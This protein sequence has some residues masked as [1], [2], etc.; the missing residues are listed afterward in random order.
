MTDEMLILA[1]SAQDMSERLQGLE[2]YKISTNKNDS[3]VTAVYSVDAYPQ[4]NFMMTS[5]DFPEAVVLK[6]LPSRNFEKAD[7]YK[8]IRNKEDLKKSMEDFGLDIAMLEI[9]NKII[10]ED[11]TE[12]TEKNIIAEVQT[13]TADST[14]IM[15]GQVDLM[16]YLVDPSNLNEFLK[17]EVSE[18]AVSDIVKNQEGELQLK[19]LKANYDG[20]LFSQHSS[21]RDAIDNPEVRKELEQSLATTASRVR[22]KGLAEIQRLNSALQNQQVSFEDAKKA[23]QFKET[24]YERKLEEETRPLINKII[25]D[26]RATHPDDTAQK[27]AEAKKHYEETLLN[28]AKHYVEQAEEDLRVRLMKE[29]KGTID[30][31]GNRDVDAIVSYLDVKNHLVDNFKQMVLEAKEGI[32]HQLPPVQQPVATPN[33]SNENDNSSEKIAELSGNIESLAKTVETFA[34]GQSEVS[35][36]SLE[37]INKY[38]KLYEE[39]QKALEEKEAA[40]QKALAEQKT[41]D[42][43]LQKAEV[44]KQDLEGAL[45]YYAGLVNPDGSLKVA[46]EEQAVEQKNPEDFVEETVEAVE[47]SEEVVEE[48]AEE[49]SEPIATPV[50]EPTESDEMETQ[51]I[52]EE[53]SEKIDEFPVDEFK[54]P[55]E[56]VTPKSKK[57]KGK[58]K[59]S[60][61]KKPSMLLRVTSALAKW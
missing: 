25:A 11:H 13:S 22:Q 59:K 17:P 15:D 19:M 7:T 61:S 29:W 24:E 54:L 8:E 16:R 20:I 44:E 3:K 41:K 9:K 32:E 57:K 12:F 26:Y 34:S 27:V 30:E 40:L 60:K 4:I 28:P 23:I 38:K 56:E 50:A 10:K 37:E 33:V 6:V 52:A 39:R 49:V 47:E 58:K 21:I 5:G 14:S 31:T 53:P 45:D 42:E 18:V 2:R 43:A 51:K 35:Q 48:K 1:V 55:D 36:A 46:E